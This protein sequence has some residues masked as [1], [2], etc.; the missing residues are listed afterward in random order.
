MSVVEDIYAGKRCDEWVTPQDLWDALNSQYNFTVALAASEENHKCSSFFSKEASFLTCDR[1][2]LQG[3]HVAWMNPPFSQSLE[4]FQRLAY[5]Q[6]RGVAIYKASNTE[7]KVWQEIIF[8]CAAWVCFLSKRVN[9]LGNG[10]SAPFPSALIGFGVA[11][12]N[13]VRGRTVFMRQVT[14]ID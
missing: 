13:T 10:K 7:T 2:M 14:R 1:R 3:D 5:A 4:F 9:Y 12:P 8:P 6:M 11:P